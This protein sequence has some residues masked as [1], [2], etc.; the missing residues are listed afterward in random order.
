M[1]QLFAAIDAGGALRFVGEVGRGADCG[2]L[3][4]E[5]ASPLV[6]RQGASNE[7]HFA[8]EAA[9]ERPACGAGAANM[10][11]RLIAEHL[12]A[13]SEGPGLPLPAYRQR[14][15]IVRAL[16]NL[17]EDVQWGAQVMGAWAWQVRA[18]AHEA[19][20]QARLDTGAGLQL[21]VSVDGEEPP[22]PE[23]E[24][25]QLVFR[26]R[27]PPAPAL[28][29]R[30]AALQ[31]IE[32]HGEL[33]WLHHPDTL[34][35]V[36]DAR[37]RLEARS[38]RIYGNW[39]ALSDQAAGSAAAEHAPAPLFYGPG[40]PVAPEQ[41]PRFACAPGHAPNVSFTFYRVSPTE[42]WL[43]YL[44]ER[45]GPVDWRNAAD[46]RYVLAPYPVPFDGWEHALPAS[47]G[48][49]DLAAGLVR[50]TAFLNAVTYLSRCATL[51]R[52]G[53]DPA[54]FQGL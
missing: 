33:V 37:E 54:A 20:A 53:R 49:A 15:A 3:C 45:E 42:A 14:V 38:R 39:L 30:Q 21:F 52:S 31:H 9:Q 34:G 7:W 5:C 13:R 40:A 44:L 12:Q 23:A 41:A 16:V 36:A 10:L 25:A 48:V 29:E 27:T 51:T 47:V 17:H 22:A 26:C 32:Q 2:C 8:H 46:K 11:R 19:V 4:P 28:R 1:T 35:R 50:C 24:M 43:L 18:A 6:A